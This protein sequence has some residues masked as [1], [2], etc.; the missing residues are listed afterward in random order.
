MRE[1]EGEGDGSVSERRSLGNAKRRT[2]QREGLCPVTVE[3]DGK[4]NNPVALILAFAVTEH[5]HSQ[6]SLL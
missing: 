1:R 6:I 5:T 2:V 3:R 4:M